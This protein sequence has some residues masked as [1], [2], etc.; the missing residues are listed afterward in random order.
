[1]TRHRP[2]RNR[3]GGGSGVM[4]IHQPMLSDPRNMLQWKNISANATRRS[5]AKA[6]PVKAVS[7]HRTPSWV[8]LGPGHDDDGDKVAALKSIAKEVCCNALII[9]TIQHKAKS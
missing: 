1:M 3:L 9:N 6:P 2:Q 4:P 8:P 7:S 5:G